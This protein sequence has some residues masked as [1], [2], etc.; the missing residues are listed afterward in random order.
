[1]T[2]PTQFITNEKGERIAVVISMA[3]YEKLLEELEDRDAIR[4][5]EEAKAA[6]EKSVPFDEAVARIEQ[7]RK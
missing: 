3:E 2:E 6:G 1:M 7:N 4:A 5:Y